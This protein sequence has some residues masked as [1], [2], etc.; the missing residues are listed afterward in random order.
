[1]E[2]HVKGTQMSICNLTV[3]LVGWGNFVLKWHPV[4]SGG[5]MPDLPETG[6]KMNE[7]GF[8][9]PVGWF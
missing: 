5:T 4:F 2:G 3:Y 6:F 8:S 7:M 1:M 9:K